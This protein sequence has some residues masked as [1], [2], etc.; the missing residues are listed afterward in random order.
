M[1]VDLYA[2]IIISMELYSAISKQKKN[3]NIPIGIKSIKNFLFI[4][5]D[6]YHFI[7]IKL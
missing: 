1:I 6:Y 4:I 5:N 3:Q 7:S 2:I